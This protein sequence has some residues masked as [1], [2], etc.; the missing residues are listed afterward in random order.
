MSHNEDVFFVRLMRGY[1]PDILPPIKNQ[2]SQT[3]QQ[4]LMAWLYVALVSG[5]LGAGNTWK[6][7]G[8]TL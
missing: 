6:G 2:G 8:E 7:E 4:K 3:F 5:S 1:K